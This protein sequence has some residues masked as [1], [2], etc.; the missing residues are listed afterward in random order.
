MG[1]SSGS[2]S[3]RSSSSSSYLGNFGCSSSSG[4][5]SSSGV[6]SGYGIVTSVQPGYIIVKNRNRESVNLRVG[7]CS[8][9]E[10]NQPN[11]VVSVS[12]K[13]FYR[14]KQSKT[15]NFELH[16]CTVATY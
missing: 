4:S 11:Y 15:N 14:G 5:G 16:D 6:T 3:S 1:G 7:S 10:A 9:I 12:D 13:L 2:G 8:R